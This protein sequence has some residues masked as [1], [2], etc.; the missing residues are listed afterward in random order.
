[1]FIVNVLKKVIILLFLVISLVAC[2]GKQNTN[3]VSPDIDVKFNVEILSQNNKNE[4]VVNS[5]EVVSFNISI[6]DP[7]KIK[8]KV[9]VKIK[10][11][12]AKINGVNEIELSANN[13]KQLIQANVDASAVANQKFVINAY[14]N[15]NE[16]ISNDL[17][18]IIK[19]IENPKIT[20]LSENK[21]NEINVIAGELADIYVT[22][23][24]AN[25]FKDNVKVK[26]KY[27]KD[28]ITGPAEIVFNPS[29]VEQIITVKVDANLEKN[30]KF[31]INAFSEK[32]IKISNAFVVIAQ[33][34]KNISINVNPEEIIAEVGKVMVFK[35]NLNIPKTFKDKVNITIKFSTKDSKNVQIVKDSCT[36]ATDDHE[37]CYGYFYVNQYDYNG[38]IALKA[39]EDKY[40]IKPVLL[41]IKT[42]PQ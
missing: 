37:V 40:N 8:N 34:A 6:T 31:V 39:I 17:T 33:E 4:I 24:N 18:I 35:V 13:S 21:T 9:L 15:K 16:K 5:G 2:I 28:G 22:L 20:L 25:L 10:Y 42:N 29:Q 38:V 14:N 26:L 3:N 23:D 1:M 12:D 41:K 30:E 32:D 19:D 11:S 27:S 36:F 7:S